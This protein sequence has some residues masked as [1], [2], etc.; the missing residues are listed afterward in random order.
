MSY[1]AF[2]QEKVTRLLDIRC[3]TKGSKKGMGTTFKVA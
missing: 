1:T 3:L 2:C